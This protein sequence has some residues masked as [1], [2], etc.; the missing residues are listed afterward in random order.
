LAGGLPQEALPR[1]E[2][3]R[4]PGGQGGGKATPLGGLFPFHQEF[5]L[6]HLGHR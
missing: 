2:I 3:R 4:L 5:F 6:P 1:F